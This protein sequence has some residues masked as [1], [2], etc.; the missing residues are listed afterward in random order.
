MRLV[1][2]GGFAEKGP[3]CAGVEAEGYRL[4][5]DAGVKT[6]PPWRD[7]YPAVSEAALRATDAIDASCGDDDV[8]AAD[9]PT[10]TPFLP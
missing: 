5:L 2:H 10:V 7:Y 4:L 3:T 9:G 8:R 1:L 6:S